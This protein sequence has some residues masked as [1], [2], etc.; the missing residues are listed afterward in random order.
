MVGH[1]THHGG[2][3][4]CPHQS[5]PFQLQPQ[6]QGPPGSAQLGE[7]FLWNGHTHKGATTITQY[8]KFGS[9]YH[10]VDCIPSL[11]LNDF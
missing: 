10:S 6:T 9:Y 7:L 4:L 2:G 5:P 3:Q 1:I 11:R 8:H